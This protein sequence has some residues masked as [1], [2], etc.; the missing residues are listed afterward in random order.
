MCPGPKEEGGNAEEADLNDSRSNAERGKENQSFR[1]DSTSKKLSNSIHQLNL[2]AHLA[3][4]R[5]VLLACYLRLS[6]PFAP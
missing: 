4:V 1:F 2:I 3:L 5:P 6:F